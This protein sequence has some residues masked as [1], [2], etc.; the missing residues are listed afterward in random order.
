MLIQNVR[1][2]NFI[3]QMLAR[4][5]LQWANVFLSMLGLLAASPVQAFNPMSPKVVDVSGGEWIYLLYKYSGMC[6]DFQIYF[7]DQRVTSGV[8]DEW[9][10]YCLVPKQASTGAV[11]VRVMC[12]ENDPLAVFKGALT[13]VD[14]PVL[15]S[16]SP[17]KQSFIP[18]PIVTTIS[19]NAFSL[20]PGTKVIFGEQSASDVQLVGNE[21]LKLTCVPP[22][23]PEGSKL[24]L[25]VDVRV[26][27]PGGGVG[28][29][30]AAY[31]YQQ[32]IPKI[33]EI[34]AKSVPAFRKGNYLIIR[35]NTV[36]PGAVRVYFGG[37]PAF[38]ETILPAGG[39]RYLV[40]CIAPP[41][42]PGKVDVTVINPDGGTYTKKDAFEYTGAA[43]T[44]FHTADRD[45]NF[46]ISVA[47]ILRLVQFSNDD[48][49]HCDATS[50]DGYASGLE[51]DH[52]CSPHTSDYDS[53]DWKIS[54]PEL[55]QLI[56]FYNL[57]CYEPCTSDP[58]G[59]C[60]PIDYSETRK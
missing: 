31:T 13:Y 2:P 29:L 38:A 42:P 52:T 55:L 8:S 44:N 46:R 15:Y 16:I 40:R 26:V 57:F 28:V 47:E 60:P 14:A 32:M 10:Y 6:N 54:L 34:S 21:V 39:D 23:Y 58:S 35:A 3:A 45:K 20:Q 19:G 12:S 43:S 50:E 1:K 56:Q 4:L 7:G 48:G 22:P 33:S 11:D 37:I 9:G 25:T 5:S 49:Y 18:E 17:N 30:P 36:V 24:P 53:Q 41:H 51:G 59:Y 27:S